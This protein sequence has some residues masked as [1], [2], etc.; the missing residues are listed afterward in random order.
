MLFKEMLVICNNQV[1]QRLTSSDC[2][3]AGGGTLDDGGEQQTAFLTKLAKEQAK[4]GNLQGQSLRLLG[5]SAK[6]AKFTTAGE[7][8]LGVLSWCPCL[9]ANTGCVYAGHLLH[10]LK[11]REYMYFG[12]RWLI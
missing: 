12:Q 6:K 4:L 9:A 2:F 5:G 3:R 1:L 7:H 8:C 10:A 11:I